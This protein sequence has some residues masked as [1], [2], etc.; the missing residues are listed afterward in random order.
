MKFVAK[1]MNN[2]GPDRYFVVAG[3]DP[4]SEIPPVPETST[5]LLLGGG[6]LGL[7]RLRRKD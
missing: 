4:E 6:L 5:L 1:W 2:A 3:D 7:T